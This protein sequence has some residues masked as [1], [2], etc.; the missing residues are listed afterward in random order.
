VRVDATSRHHAG[1]V[2]PESPT[3]EDYIVVPHMGHGAVEDCLTTGQSAFI[4][5]VTMFLMSMIVNCCEQGTRCQDQDQDQATASETEAK[6]EA[7]CSWPI[8]SAVF[9]WPL[10]IR[11]V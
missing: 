4:R 3:L 7:Q 10:V 11:P 8:N 9:P 2:R 6:T 1:K 5:A